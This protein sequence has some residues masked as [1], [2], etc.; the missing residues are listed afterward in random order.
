[1]N[2]DLPRRYRIE[3]IDLLR[4]V[5]MVI[6]ALDH[7]RDYFN[8]G[9][10]FSD[11]TNLAV[12]TPLL[13]FTR[14]I[15]HF[16]APVFVFL[17]GTAAFLYGTRKESVREV[18]WFL[19]TRGVWLLFLEL[20][21]VN[22]AWTFD[23]THSLTALQVI[24]A[25][26]ISMI[27]LSLVVYFPGWLA[28]AIGGLLVAGHNVLDPIV[29]EGTTVRHFLWYALHQQSAIPLGPDSAIFIFYPVL[30]WIGLMMLGYAFGALYREG[31]DAGKRRSMLLRMSL[32]ALGLF[33]LLRAFNLYG[34]MDQWEPQ[35]TLLFSVFSFV[36]TTKYPPSLL[37]LLM[38]MGPALLF[39]HLTEGIENR[40]TRAF[41]IIGRVPLFFYVLH[42]Y[43]IHL[44]AIGGVVYAGM[45]WRDMILTARTFSTA[46]LADYGY[47]LKVVYAVWII[48]VVL[49]F[50]LCK[51]YN[52]Y[53]A[54][55][56]TKWW[57]SYL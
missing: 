11:P 55:N 2:V 46:S 15:T 42:L 38:T 10:F 52:E 50:P 20:T 45:A 14:W 49:M 31:Y 17:A 7:A 9:S 27:V 33:G 21:I 24:W 36:N 8:L 16:C 5:V 29:L 18:S 39:L 41:V 1:M 25:I 54:K 37:F 44:L 23:I 35:R 57:L 3:S 4:G 40:V 56:R 32:G 28:V 26:G 34:D 53:K 47:N 22:F 13:F 19:L 43:L 48:V 51:Y 12:T 30:P 6:M